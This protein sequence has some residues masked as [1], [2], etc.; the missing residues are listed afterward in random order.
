MHQCR[1]LIQQQ[2]PLGSPSLHPTTQFG[3]V[4]PEK[5]NLAS[6]TFID[7]FVDPNLAAGFG[8]R[9]ES[10]H[11]HRRSTLGAASMPHAQS[12]NVDAWGPEGGI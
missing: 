11:D 1:S 6:T 3:D 8:R 4:I 9:R 10:S 5:L 2:E 7:P 12:T